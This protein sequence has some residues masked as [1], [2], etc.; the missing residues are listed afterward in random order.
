MKT[1]AQ[2]ATLLAAVT[3]ASFATTF[4]H[5]QQSAPAPSAFSGNHSGPHSWTT[6]QLVTSTVHQAW[7]LSG[8]S[9]DQFFQMVEALS[10]LSAKNRDITLPD[11]AAAGARA[12][13][14]IKMKAK[15]DPDQL[16]Y[17]I[18]DQAVQYSVRPHPATAAKQP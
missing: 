18:V 13:N 11:N 10:E 16:L 1:I 17:V 6:E 12:G 14:W 7:L 15:Q 2:K 9:E 5:A 8:K 3:V 4:A